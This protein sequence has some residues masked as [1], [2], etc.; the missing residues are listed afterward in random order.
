MDELTPLAPPER[1]PKVHILNYNGLPMWW[2]VSLG[3][4]LLVIL[5]VGSLQIALRLAKVG[6]PVMV[7]EKSDEVGA[8]SI[9]KSLLDEPKK[10][11]FVPK[12]NDSFTIQRVTIDKVLT[13]RQRYVVKTTNS[14]I[15]EVVVT[16]DT[17]VVKPGT[18]EK[19]SKGQYVIRMQPDVSILNTLKSSD[20]ISIAYWEKDWKSSN[21]VPLLELIAFA[22]YEK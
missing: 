4:L 3:L 17:M 5:V 21:P 14:E 7:V 11:T 2:Y 20:T 8:Q 13:P 18:P 19:D 15:K 1:E 16:E 12:E 9:V 10:T 22:Q 6:V